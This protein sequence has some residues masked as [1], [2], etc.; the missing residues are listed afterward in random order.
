ML[1]L[2]SPLTCCIFLRFTIP[3]PTRTFN[4]DGSGIGIA[5]AHGAS[6]GDSPRGDLLELTA[7][8][9]CAAREAEAGSRIV[10]ANPMPA[11]CE[12]L[13]ATG[14]SGAPSAMAWACASSEFT[15]LIAVYPVMPSSP[16]S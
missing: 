6:C 15:A 16:S 1:A 8:I 5:S 14:T 7:R 4:A 3:P 11:G 10:V 2:R 12:M 13:C 9:E